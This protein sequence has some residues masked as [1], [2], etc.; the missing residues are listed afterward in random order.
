MLVVNSVLVEPVIEGCF[1]IDVISEISRAGW[2]HKEMWL[3]G[4]R[5]ITIK[6]FACSLIVIFDQ[7]KAE[8]AFLIRF[9]VLLVTVEACLSFENNILL[10]KKYIQNLSNLSL[11]RKVIHERKIV[12][13]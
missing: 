10:I 5:V 2:S 6:F 13:F 4:N 11:R 7:A 12:K 3:I 9:R 8:S 1:E